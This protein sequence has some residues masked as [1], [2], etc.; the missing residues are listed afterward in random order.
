MGDIPKQ[1]MFFIQDPFTEEVKGPLT[2]QQL[3][4]WF[5]QGSVG[6]WGVSKSAAGP[7]TPASQV[8][9][10]QP[11]IAPAPALQQANPPSMATAITSKKPPSAGMAGFQRFDAAAAKRYGIP[12][13]S[14]ALLLSCGYM[15]GR[16]HE[17]PRLNETQAGQNQSAIA[18]NDST[19]KRPSQQNSG[20][21]DPV[22]LFKEQVLDRTLANSRRVYLI[23]EAPGKWWYEIHDCRVSYDIQKTDSLVSPLIA[24]VT[25]DPGETYPVYDNGNHWGSREALLKAPQQPRKSSPDK[26]DR[27]P[28]K[29]VFE[30]GKW[31]YAPT[32]YQSKYYG[33]AGAPWPIRA[34]KYEDTKKGWKRI[35]SLDDI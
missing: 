16:F 17:S 19:A 23:N 1:P 9:G 28:F 27:G 32:E 11:S 24:V 33:D 8:K 14:G 30:N 2:A 25:L 26:V 31:T 5:T 20:G 29:F 12:L 13:L 18:S 15:L 22:Q 10:L 21:S 6:D 34:E 35:Q 7:W 3:K 4:Q